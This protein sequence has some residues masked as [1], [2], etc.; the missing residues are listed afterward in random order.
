[1]QQQNSTKLKA[2]H[3]KLALQRRW[4]RGGDSFFTFIQEKCKERV[5]FK[6]YLEKEVA[7]NMNSAKSGKDHYTTTNA[8]LGTDLG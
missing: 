3:I 8:Q 5:V 6:S 7:G 2:F 1:M 4:K